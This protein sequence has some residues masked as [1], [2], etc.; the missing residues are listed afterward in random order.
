[1][2]FAFVSA[3]DYVNSINIMVYRY[4]FVLYWIG[5]FCYAEGSPWNFEATRTGRLQWRN[6]ERKI[7]TDLDVAGAVTRPITDLRGGDMDRR[8]AIPIDYGSLIESAYGWCVNLGAPSALVAGAVV[9]T[10][11]E[12]I[13]SGDL[14]TSEDDSFWVQIGKK[15]THLLLL[16]AFALEVVSIF[17]TTVTGTML[18]SRKPELMAISTESSTP[19]EFLRE[20]FEF[21]YLT[22]RIFFL[23]GLINW[24]AAIALT[25]VLPP[26]S[27]DEK[28]HRPSVEA[29][30]KFVGFSIM[31]VIA[32]MLSFYNNHMTFYKNY[33]AMLYR[34]GVVTMQYYFRIVGGPQTWPPRPLSL[35]LSPLLIIS[36]Y[37]GY[38]ALALYE[39]PTF[40]DGQG[41]GMFSFKRR[42]NNQTT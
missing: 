7:R 19:L 24:L 27:S 6:H 13:H 25:H 33:L 31:T 40:D 22:A 37:W 39:K 26:P 10:L 4:G 36:M 18:L 17:V 29:F 42:Q 35:I 2:R 1:M 9:A 16:S 23:Q 20:N 28:P 30:N 12:N 3:H 32:V 38:K 34:W 11:Y 14:V 5:L 41:R 15:V 21:E 8:L